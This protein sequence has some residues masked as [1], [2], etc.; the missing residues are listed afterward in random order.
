MRVVLTR[1]NG[2]DQ[3]AVPTKEP[4]PSSLDFGPCNSAWVPG[5]RLFGNPETGCPL[6]AMDLEIE[7]TIMDNSIYEARWLLAPVFSLAVVFVAVG[8]VAS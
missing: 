6:I 8:M 2:P 1:A 5:R 3:S 4:L 7:V